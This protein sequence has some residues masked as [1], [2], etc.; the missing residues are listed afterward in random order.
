MEN[1]VKVPKSFTSY[2]SEILWGLGLSQ[3]INLVIFF[4]L[5][6]VSVYLYFIEQY[7][8]VAFGLIISFLPLSFVIEFQ[9]LSFYALLRR[10][11]KAYTRKRKYFLEN[12]NY[13][14]SISNMSYIKKDLRGFISIVLLFSTIILILIGILFFAY[15]VFFLF[16]SK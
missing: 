1:Y 12:K 13:S 8:F 10:K 2:K 3:V 5:I 11:I 4:A 7:I 9:G 15:Y 16:K 6:L 14:K